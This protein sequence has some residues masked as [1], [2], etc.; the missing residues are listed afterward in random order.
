MYY[1]PL[2]ATP[3]NPLPDTTYVGGF[4]NDCLN[5]TNAKRAIHGVPA[6]VLDP[7]VSYN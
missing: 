6:L 1:F 5:T 7:N 2:V 4:E 3:R